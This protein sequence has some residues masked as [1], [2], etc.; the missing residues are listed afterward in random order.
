MVTRGD[1]RVLGFVLVLVAT[2]MVIELIG[3]VLTNSLALLSDAGHMVSDVG[4]LVISLVAVSLA[5][6]PPTPERPFGLRR[7]EILAALINGIVLVGIDVYII[8]NSYL[9]LLEPQEVQ[10]LGM[11]G[12]ASG[13]LVINLISVKI[14]SRA[15][16]RSLNIRSA[17]LHVIADAV[18]S[19]GAIAAG[20]IMF[21][22][23]FYLVDALV[24][25][26]IGILLIPSIWRLLK[27]SLNILLEACPI[28]VGVLQVKSELRK[29][30]R[31]KDAHDL[32][33]WS[34]SSGIYSLSVH[35]VIE[36]MKHGTVVLKAAKSMLDEKFGIHHA[37]IQ[38][39]ELCEDEMIH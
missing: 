9:R 21:F 20:V 37:T 17:F 25:L 31:V 2:Y 8:Y 18:G 6:R 39:E 36:N 22:T 10:S 38:I 26:L 28:D 13:G 35:L 23:D 27:E 15:S 14:L 34:I 4:G 3:G 11:L 29:V 30:R 16:K 33:I 24:G 7:L 1:R 19:V 32:H 5:C 12:V